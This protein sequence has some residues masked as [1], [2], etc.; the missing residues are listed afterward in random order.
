M[1]LHAQIVEIDS[2]SGRTFVHY[3][4]FK[5]SQDEW[6]T[7]DRL[8]LTQPISSNKA[9]KSVASKRQMALPNAAT[10]TAVIDSKIPMPA[11]AAEPLPA[12]G[13]VYLVEDR[14][15]LF[16][17]RLLQRREDGARIEFQAKF[18]GWGTNY[19][20]WVVAQQV[21]VYDAVDGPAFVQQQERLAVEARRA[22]AAQRAQ[23]RK[24][25]NRPVASELPHVLQPALALD[26]AAPRSAVGRKR[27]AAP[28]TLAIDMRDGDNEVMM[29]KQKKCLSILFKWKIHGKVEVIVYLGF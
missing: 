22:T 8:S 29:R 12:T 4:R 24:H 15:A 3:C 2:T 1:F 7:A 25:A 18:E 5:K 27:K 10:P 17:A 11:L 19:N 14:G 6:V 23:Q 21:H 26:V 16:R 20:T 9:T 13:Q 28:V